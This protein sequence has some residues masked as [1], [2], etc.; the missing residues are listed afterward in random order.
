MTEEQITQAIKEAHDLHRRG[1]AREQLVLLQSLDTSDIAACSKTTQ[2]TAF[3]ALGWAYSANYR[4][5]DALVAF[6]AGKALA[7]QI[8]AESLIAESELGK[9]RAHRHKQPGGIETLYYQSAQQRFLDLNAYHDAG[10]CALFLACARL[11]LTDYE[12]AK[13]A[14]DC[15]NEL[16]TIDPYYQ[17]FYYS[18]SGLFKEKIGAAGTADF[19]TAIALFGCIGNEFEVAVNRNNLAQALLNHGYLAQAEVELALALPVLKESVRPSYYLG[20]LETMRNI[21]L[22]AGDQVSADRIAEKIADLMHECETGN[23]AA[24]MIS[25]D[26][27]DWVN[28]LN[29]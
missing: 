23:L 28:L 25:A 20:A 18:Y 24:G 6:D 15:A 17:G 22:Q 14:L 19:N 21:K 1:L 10:R 9:G 26:W 27:Q 13:A 12:G 8:N 11:W 16:L 29:R 7:E 5:D 2:I 4:L 3:L